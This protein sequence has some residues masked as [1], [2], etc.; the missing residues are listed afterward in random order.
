MQIK[1]LKLSSLLSI[2]GGISFA[3]LGVAWAITH[4]STGIN[5]KGSWLGIDNLTFSQMNLVYSLCFIAAMWG[6]SQVIQAKTKLAIVSYR[7]A[8]VSLVFQMISQ[9]LQYYIV[10]PIRDV[11]STVVTLGFLMY[12][13]SW[14]IFSISMMVLGLALRENT[15]LIN[16]LL[17]LIGL[18]TIVTFFAEGFWIGEIKD[19]DQRDIILG[20]LKLPLSLCWILLG[21]KMYSFLSHHKRA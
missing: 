8:L 17:F 13:L 10:S 7:I 12:W 20:I 18:L 14:T 15:I 5:R 1:S 3:F 16:I 19:D 4:G 11:E 21:T 9:I 6:L 2:I